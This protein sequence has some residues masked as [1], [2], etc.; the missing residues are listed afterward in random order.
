[1]A[2]TQTDSSWRE[3]YASVLGTAAEAVAVVRPGSR[4]YAGGWTS[5]PP[6]LCGAL[7]ARAGE[8]RDVM[9]GTYLTPF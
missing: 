9:V 4:V 5:V 2:Q 1:M 3:K 7:A 6:M 8:L